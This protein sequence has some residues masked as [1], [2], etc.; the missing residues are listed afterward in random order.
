MLGGIARSVYTRPGRIDDENRFLLSRYHTP[1]LIFGF[2][3]FFRCSRKKLR[4]F[5]T[6]PPRTRRVRTP[7]D[8]GNNKNAT[9]KTNAEGKNTILGRK[10][11]YERKKKLF[12]IDMNVR[13]HNV[14]MIHFLLDV[15]G[16]R[17]PRLF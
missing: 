10:R 12:I 9:G 6:A 7:F 1:R 8:L 2:R 13:L 17:A 5:R 11:N 14:I 4:C 3:L 15:F 16:G